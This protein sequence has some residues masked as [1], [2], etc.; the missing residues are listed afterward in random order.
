[1]G[2]E[3][4]GT[5]PEAVQPLDSVDPLFWVSYIVPR[6]RAAASPLATRVLSPSEIV[7]RT[8]EKSATADGSTEDL[9]SGSA[10]PGERHP[11]PKPL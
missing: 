4:V 3:D 1:M 8:L 11:R 2:R 7:V 9:C 10:N 6:K 5:N